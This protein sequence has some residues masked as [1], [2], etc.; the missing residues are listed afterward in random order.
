MVREPE[1]IDGW[2]QMLDEW[3]RAEQTLQV[4]DQGIFDLELARTLSDCEPL[5]RSGA[6]RASATITS[7]SYRTA[8]NE[9][10]AQLLPA[11]KLRA[12]DLWSAGAEASQLMERWRG[13]SIDQPGTPRPCS[14]LGELRSAFASCKE[15]LEALAATINASPAD[16]SVAT[17]QAFL[18]GLLGDVVTL[19]KLPE[20]HRLRTSLNAQGL[21]PLL[22]ELEPRGVDGTVACQALRFAW[23]SSI[24]EHIQLT[25]SHIGAFDGDQQRHVVA[26]FQQADREHIETTAQ[27]VR[28]RCAEQATAAQDANQE[29][30][31]LIRSEAA[32]K[33]K[34][35]PI[36]ELFSAAPDVM[37]SLKPCWVMSPLIVSQIL[38]SDQPHFDVVVFDEASQVRPA[39][40]LPAILRGRQLVVA[41]DERQLPPTAF[42][43]SA[44]SEDGEQ[45]EPE[46]ALSIDDSFESILEAMDPFVGFKMLEWHY[47]SRDERLIAFSNA[48]LYDHGLTTFPGIVGP[49]CIQHIQVP[50][51]AGRPDTEV[52]SG[53]EVTKVV[54][55]ILEHAELRPEQSLGVIAMGIKHS[56]QIDEALRTG[57]KKRNPHTDRRTP[58][59]HVVD[60]RRCRRC[61]HALR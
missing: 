31:A 2:Q 33:R 34:H 19:G 61:H 28:R 46:A 5:S 60:S 39:E 55:L 52:S 11:A 48:H 27:R 29:G 41:G 22:L 6:A 16:D 43:A 30:A 49:D 18:D 56:E 17:A 54:G 26:E 7:A 38:P 51:V 53:A 12:G 23:L 3:A 13:V 57:F 14:S 35:L 20:L 24:R 58:P 50:W 8:R 9:L 1:T 36:R 10:R 37:T 4:F 32:K 47:R 42:F 44:S 59:A 15:G 25:D 21:E 40:A 45:A